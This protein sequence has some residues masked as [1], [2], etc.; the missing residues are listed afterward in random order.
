LLLNVLLLVPVTYFRNI[1][2]G[3]HLV[4]KPRT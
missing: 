2:S 3:K 4:N 1:R